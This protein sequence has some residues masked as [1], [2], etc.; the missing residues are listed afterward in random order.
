MERWGFTGCLTGIGIFDPANSQ[1]QVHTSGAHVHEITLTEEQ[2][3]SAKG[4]MNKVLTGIDTSESTAHKHTIDAK[5]SKKNKQWLIA[6]CNTKSAKKGL[7][8]ED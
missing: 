4:P 1:R 3:N 5:W 6:K 2:V 8:C 7:R